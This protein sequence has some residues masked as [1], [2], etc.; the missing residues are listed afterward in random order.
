MSKLSADKVEVLAYIDTILTLIEKYPTLNLGNIADDI[1]LGVSVNPFDFLLSIIS[2]KVSDSEMID[3]L[4]NL[5]TASLG[6]VESSIIKDACKVSAG[7][8]SADLCAFPEQL[9]M[10]VN[11][12]NTAHIIITVFFFIFITF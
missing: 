4:V 10:L 3:W 5:L 12:V 9:T 1:N 7:I 2:K 11:M 6:G 8:V